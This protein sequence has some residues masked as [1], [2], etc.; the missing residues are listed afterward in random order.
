MT[1][2]A[3]H[4]KIRLSCSWYIHVDT[5]HTEPDDAELIIYMV[6]ESKGKH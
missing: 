4:A 6:F 2:S 5:K 3:T 1:C